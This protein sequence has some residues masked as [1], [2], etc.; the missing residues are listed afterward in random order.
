MDHPHSFE[1][2]IAIMT[3]IFAELE[4]KAVQES[5]LTN[6][7]MKQLVYLETIAEMRQPTFGDLAKKLGISKPS[8]TA[9][10]GKLMQNGYVEKVQSQDDRRSFTVLLTEKGRNLSRIHENLHRKIAAHFAAALDEGELHQL[11]DL[12]H[13]AMKS[14]LSKLEEI[15]D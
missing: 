9:I 13:K 12:L 2:I 4:S 1:E 8:V 11:A 15:H 14:T 10:V 7:S 3:R 5:E 6:L